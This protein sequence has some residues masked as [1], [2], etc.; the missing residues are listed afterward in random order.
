MQARCL[1]FERTRRWDTVAVAMKTGMNRL[2]ATKSKW[3][4]SKGSF[5]IASNTVADSTTYPPG[6]G[7]IQYTSDGD[8]MD[9]ESVHLEFVWNQSMIQFVE[10]RS[11]VIQT[12]TK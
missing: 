11:I 8:N 3:I 5:F 12:V 1:D 7:N 2:D 10:I 4:E 9:P 6:G